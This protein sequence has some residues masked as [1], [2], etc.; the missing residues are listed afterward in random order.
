MRT[1]GIALICLG[2][3]T[4]IA[5]YQGTIFRSRWVRGHDWKLIPTII[6]GSV[7]LI[8]IQLVFRFTSAAVIPAA[9]T[10]F[11]WGFLV[12]VIIPSIQ[13]QVLHA[14][15]GAPAPL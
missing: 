15:S 10:V 11:A 14:A 8:T 7:V 5:A 12:F 2:F 6:L 3:V 1:R 13:M 9:V 4:P